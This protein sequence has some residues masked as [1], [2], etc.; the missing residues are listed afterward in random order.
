MNFYEKLL[1]EKVLKNVGVFASGV[2][3]GTVGIK[4]LTSKD[5]KNVYTKTLAAGLRAKDCVMTT[6]MKVQETAED[7]LAEAQE[8]NVKRAEQQFA[9]ENEG[10]FEEETVEAEEKIEE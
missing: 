10:F 9:N 3:F 6:T 4:L 5:A 7:I 1:N 2:L 8:I